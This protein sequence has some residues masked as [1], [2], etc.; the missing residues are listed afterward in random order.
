MSVRRSGVGIREP[1][2]ILPAQHA[3]P[4]TEARG[5]APVT[6]ERYDLRRLFRDLRIVP[7]AVVIAAVVVFAISS[8][9]QKLYTAEAQL[10]VSSGLG[11]DPANSDVLTAPRIAQTYATLATTRAVLADAIAAA[12]VQVS[13]ADLLRNVRVSADPSSPFIVI[14]V[15]D[16]QADRAAAIANALADVLIRRATVPATAEAPKTEVLISVE[17]AIVPDQPSAPRVI[18]NT[19]LAGATA[20]VLTLALVATVAYVRGD[21]EERK[22]TTG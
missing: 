21:R 22:A 18:F 20:F 7:L 15:T 10:V 13:P 3:N 19:V 9:S 5:P 11:T 6:I 14:D 17:E 4:A 2:D 16:P 12:G 8:A 1:A